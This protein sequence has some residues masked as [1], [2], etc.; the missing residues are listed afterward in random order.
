MAPI[1]T[2]LFA[3][4]Q[5]VP[6]S[7][8]MWLLMLF[9]TASAVLAETPYTITDLGVLPGEA[10][11][12]A[13]AMN[14]LGQVVGTSGRHGFVWSNGQMSVIPQIRDD[15]VFSRPND[16]NNLGIVV[17]ED[18]RPAHYFKATLY[19]T[20]NNQKKYAHSPVSDWSR[21]TAINDSGDYVGYAGKR[22]FKGR[23]FFIKFHDENPIYIRD[24]IGVGLLTDINNNR[25][26][27][28]HRGYKGA[29]LWDEVE[30]WRRLP[31][32][33]NSRFTSASRINDL[34]EV[35]GHASY[36]NTNSQRPIIWSYTD[37]IQD[38]AGNELGRGE[39]VSI[40][41]YSQIIGHFNNRPMIW[42]DKKA[43][44]ISNL[45][46]PSS[47]WQLSEV[48]D[49]NDR[50]QITG[51]GTINGQT[52]A[53]LL[54]P[55]INN[56]TTF[57]VKPKSSAMP[58]ERLARWDGA[59]WQS[60]GL[61]SINSGTVHVL[62][63]GWGRKQLGWVELQDGLARAWENDQ[64]FFENINLAARSLYE[65]YEGKEQENV[66]VIAYSWIDQSATGTSP[67]DPAGIA[68]RKAAQSR[69]AADNAAY[70]L[71]KALQLAGVG[72]STRIQF[73]GHSH[74]ARV[75]TIAAIDLENKGHQID[76][77]TLWDSPETT[78]LGENN[79]YQDAFNNLQ[80][81][82]HDYAGAR[83]K[84]TIGRG[85]TETFVD[86][87]HSVFG[88][89]YNINGV[90]NVDL[91]GGHGDPIKWYA[92]ATT[93]D[94]GFAYGWSPLEN[95]DQIVF[96]YPIEYRQQSNDP[97]KLEPVTELPDAVSFQIKSL[98]LHELFSN[99]AVTNTDKG[100]LLQENSPAFWHALFT[101]EENDIAI[102]FQ[103]EFLNAGD[104]DQFGVWVD[105]ELKYL[106]TGEIIGSH[107][108]TPLLDIQNLNPG[109][110]LLTLALHS[111]GDVNAELLVGGIRTIS[112]PEPT[113]LIWMS[114]ISLICMRRWACSTT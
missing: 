106:I 13:T 23:T 33:L 5:R 50:G 27:L 98:Q 93:A 40:N 44:A 99:G 61:N 17:G 89:Q 34:G 26:V 96:T 70:N 78:L 64:G 42:I 3:T 105:D 47:A 9:F 95:R 18:I 97:L 51:T 15:F 22:W 43:Y 75:A 82:L 25:Q 29:H 54:T 109:Q 112:I 108:N 87:Y 73:L 66:H 8:L 69:R 102:T 114:L 104:G 103:Y 59:S 77:L 41:N 83:G 90:A 48:V 4:L 60:V 45:V 31:L 113:S 10:V 52:H 107:L 85:S 57:K 20:T 37:G 2:N 58:I 19:D 91:F 86:N 94:N 14:N 76:H 7:L 53:F 21:A 36:L 38:L 79:Y 92:D 6:H 56:A 111:Y 24:D 32:L 11:S 63:H 80:G 84:L 49:I 30:G 65:S 28:G 88:R 12:Y 68:P 110:H 71:S 46:N 72:D 67:L 74:G 35:V 100:V 101:T 81:L 55:N 39:A 16:I 1:K 62:V